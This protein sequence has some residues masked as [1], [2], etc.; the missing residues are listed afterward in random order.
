M[1]LFLN[2]TDQMQCLTVAESID[3][4]ELSMRQM[5]RG[6]AIRRPR[7]DNFLPT[8]HTDEFFCF[9]SMGELSENRAK[10]RCVSSRTS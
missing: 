3:G 1:T 5:A 7:I 9:S 10:T 8:S 4:M 6:D 2:N